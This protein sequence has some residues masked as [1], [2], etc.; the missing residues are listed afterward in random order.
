MEDL[1]ET[2]NHIFNKKYN[3]IA[4]TDDEWLREKQQYIVNIKNGI[5]YN[6]KEEINRKKDDKKERTPV[7]DLIDIIGE[8]LIEIE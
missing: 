8:D 2:L 7:D 1:E 6:V 3:I 5:K 4:L